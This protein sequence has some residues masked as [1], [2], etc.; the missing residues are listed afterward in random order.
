MNGGELSVHFTNSV[1]VTVV[2]A[3]IVLWRY[4][5]AILGGM[6]QGEGAVLP[7]PAA[8]MLA[9]VRN[10]A[11]DLRAYERSM[12]WRMVAAARRS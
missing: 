6:M 3:L 7:L 1:L 10:A 4:R 2:V 11:C 9:E 12:R 5:Q 8:P